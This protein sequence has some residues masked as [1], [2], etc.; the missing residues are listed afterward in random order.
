MLLGYASG[1]YLRVDK[2]GY[3][4]GPLGEIDLSCFV[5]ANDAGGNITCKSTE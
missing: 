4:N 1:R 3:Q 2:T 5:V